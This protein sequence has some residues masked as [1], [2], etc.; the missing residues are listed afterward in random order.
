MLPLKRKLPTEITSINK[1]SRE[2][3]A[4]NK[5]ELCM[6]SGTPTL[7]KIEREKGEKLLLDYLIAWLM[8][9]NEK[10]NLARPMPSSTLE[11]CAYYIFKNYPYL[12]MAD[13]NLV[14]TRAV[15]GQYGKMYESLSMAKVL[16]WFTDYTE[17]RMGIAEGLSDQ[18]HERLKG[19]PRQITVRDENIRLSNLAGSF[20]NKKKYKPNI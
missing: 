10:L 1:S 14:F 11:E 4:Y 7:G 3:M 15:S 20:I 6:Q 9:V 13:I 19:E 16:E 8:S 17:E 2:L 5:P 18:E 12:N